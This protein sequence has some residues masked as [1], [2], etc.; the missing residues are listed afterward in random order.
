IEL[1]RDLVEQMLDDDFEVL[2][3]VDGPEG[4]RMAE[5]E[6][7]A[8]I[9]MDISLPG[10]DGL[11]VT[12]RIK[13][14]PLTAGIPVVA[15]TAHAMVSDRERALTAGCDDFLTKPIDERL[16]VKTTWAWIEASKGAAPERS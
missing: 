4:L 15:L 14:N 1:N 5:E 7:P 6:Q 2:M 16:L 3:A 9:L 12:R 10:M 11:E 13:A 8:L